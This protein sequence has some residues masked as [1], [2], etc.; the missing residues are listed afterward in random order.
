MLC[1]TRGTQ[2]S[3]F[4]KCYPSHPG[5]MQ[6]HPSEPFMLAANA[7][8]EIHV[9]VRP[10]HVGSKLLHIN[11]VDQECHQLVR[12]WLVTVASQPPVVSKAFEISIPVGG[13]RG[14][15]KKIT[16]TNPYPH[17]KVILA[18]NN[19]VATL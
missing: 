7:L 9:G 13:G 4:V 1:C 6:V 8:Q 17:S 5:E 15:N 10:R 16:F 14:S 19:L 3:R 2:T 11:V 18:T 12:S